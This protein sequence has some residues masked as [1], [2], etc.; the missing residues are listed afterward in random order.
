MK[1]LCPSWKR[2]GFTLVELMVTVAII[3]MLVALL[4]PAV[5]S[6]RESA[7]RVQCQSNLRQ[8][9][10]SIHSFHSRFGF[11]PPPP[12]NM[13]IHWHYKILPDLEQN[14]LFRLT[15]SEISNQFPWSGLTA[16]T[17][18]I[19]VFE[20]ASDPNNSSRFKTHRI[21]GIRFASTNYIGVTGQSLQLNDG[22]V[23]SPYGTFAGNRADGSIRVRFRDV[24][25]GLSNTLS[26]AERSIGDQPV[27]GAWAS[28]QEYG[29]QSIGTLEHANPWIGMPLGGM[30]TGLIQFGPGVSKN[31]C[32]QLHPW[33]H[34]FGG[35]N[36]SIA[37]A[38]V[39]CIDYSI[40]P[41]ALGAMS[42]IAGQEDIVMAMT[43]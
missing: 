7:R 29:S 25:D 12:R 5:Q 32:D 19:S 35:A 30:C 41:I 20:C 10:L 28:S 31:V 3:G 13:L 40:D 38:S 27:V 15:E 33:S 43:E 8:M 9:A 4:I 24:S 18:P 26:L 17:T 34:H 22:I 11:V 6:A 1:S 36:F 23:P 2:F 37:D 16:L 42:S 14:T 39:R 21:S